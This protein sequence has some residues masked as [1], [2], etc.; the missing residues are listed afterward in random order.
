MAAA[1]FRPGFR[2]SALD[3]AVILAG[4]TGAALAAEVAWW[5]GTAI[6]F[7]IGHF[8]LFCNVL[9][10]ARP[11]ELAWTACFLALAIASMTKGMPPWSITFALSS[12]VTLVVL[13][14]QIR[15]PSYHGIGWQRLNPDLPQWWD[16]HGGGQ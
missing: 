4:S 9:R 8:F 13:A 1:S 10:A 12:L 14:L 3:A 5:M 6:A 7:V 11:L 2:L 16:E 15:R